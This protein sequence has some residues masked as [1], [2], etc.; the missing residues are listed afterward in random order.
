MNLPVLTEY[1]TDFSNV[2]TPDQLTELRSIAKAYEDK[3][4]TQ[5]VAVLFPNRN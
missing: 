4:S 3:T 1:V 2:L 5:I